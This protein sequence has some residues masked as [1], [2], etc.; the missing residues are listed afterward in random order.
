MEEA[1]AK[2]SAAAGDQATAAEFT[3]LAAKRKAA[4]N[5]YFWVARE[6]RYA[7]WD[8]TTRGPT[9]RVS[10]AM[11]YPLFAGAASPQQAA[12]VAATTRRTLLAPGGVRTTPLRT[13]QQ[14]DAP[15]GWAP[16][17][18]VAIAGFDKSGQPDLAREIAKR[19]I[20][21][22]ATT[23]GETGKMLEKYDVDE[24]KPGGGGEYPTQDGFGWTN[25]VASAILEK[26]GAA[27]K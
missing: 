10:A 3:R 2:R 17:Q 14:W 19:W 27:L 26:Y 4:L 18:W 1:I 15:N 6:G 20:D 9:P 12:A 5:R 8:R 11:L 16:L 7:D 24:R 25:G 22:V 21:T 13:G 23:Y